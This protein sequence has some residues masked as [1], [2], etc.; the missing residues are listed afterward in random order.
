M[1]T[2]RSGWSRVGF[3][4]SLTVVVG[5]ALFLPTEGWA[6][7]AFS[8]LHGKACG[9]CHTAFP[10]LNSSGEEF[11]LSGYHRFEGG[12]EVPTVPPVKIGEKIE[13]PG[14]VPLSLLIEAG[15]DLRD[16][17]ERERETG[18]SSTTSRNSF[19]LEAVTLF[20]GGTL[21]RHVSFFTHVP[22]AETEF[23]EGDFVLEG[24]A[25]PDV[26]FIALNDIL[27]SDLFNLKLGAID[28]PLLSGTGLSPQRRLSVAPYEIFEATAASL[29]GIE[30]DETGERLGI[31]EAQRVFSLAAHSQLGAELYGNIYPEMLGVPDLIFRY[32]VGVTNASNR[33]VDNNRNKAVYGRLETRYLNQ[34]LGFFGFYAGNTVD[35]EPP[36]AF[37]GRKNRAWRL[38]PDLSLRFFEENLNLISQ[39]LWGRDSS[40]TGLGV[41]LRYWGGFTEVNYKLPLGK[42]GDLLA[43]LRFDYVFAR[44]FDDHDA[45]EAIG[46]EGIRTKP[47]IFAVTGGL[48]YFFWENFKVVAEYTFRE[49]KE[50][51]SAEESTREHE[52]VRDHIFTVRFNVVF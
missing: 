33:E 30:E 43:L 24:P 23:E 13:L 11:R 16:V 26:G 14:I 34:S 19:N 38:G 44:K 8:R 21:G 22:L 25:A 3:V 6:I 51:L 37:P 42:P 1:G 27:V 35:Q 15:W 50:R 28:P 20:A 39:F 17:K 45:A 31:A 52:R 5:M 18:E 10:K 32:N 49:E 46:V 7:P 41:P 36:A 9:A 40:P 2:S 47:R 12:I 29:L 4:V 48:Q